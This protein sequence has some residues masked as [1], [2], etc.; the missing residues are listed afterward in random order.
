MISKKLKEHLFSFYVILK[1]RGTAN[2]NLAGIVREIATH[3]KSLS[4]DSNSQQSFTIKIE[5]DN[6]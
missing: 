2:P 6:T 5:A 3:A 4:E 1:A